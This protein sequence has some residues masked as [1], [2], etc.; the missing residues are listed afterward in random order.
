MDTAIWACDAVAIIIT[1][2]N[3]SAHTDCKMCMGFRCLIFPR[4]PGVAIRPSQTQ[5]FEES[6]RRGVVFDEPVLRTVLTVFS[7]EGCD[8]L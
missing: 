3:T 8:R 1:N 4:F 5:L 6:A 7:A 2:A